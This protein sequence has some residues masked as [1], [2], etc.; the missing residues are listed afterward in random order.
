MPNTQNHQ[1]LE[2]LIKRRENIKNELYLLELAIMSIELNDA[3]HPNDFGLPI[4]RTAL[5]N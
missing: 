5:P 2:S 1:E 4:R 3:F